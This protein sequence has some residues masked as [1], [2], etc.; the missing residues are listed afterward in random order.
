MICLAAEPRIGVTGTRSGSL[1]N[2]EQNNRSTE[3]NV[4]IFPLALMADTASLSSGSGI[5]YGGGMIPFRRALN[6]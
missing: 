6:T 5:S 1:W 3:V 2:I 4:E